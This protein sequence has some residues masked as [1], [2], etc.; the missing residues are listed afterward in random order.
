MMQNLK[1]SHQSLLDRIQKGV[2]A[3]VANDDS[4]FGGVLKK[5]E[6]RT[7]VRREIIFYAS[8]LLIFVYLAVGWANN[9]IC[10]L[11]GF[12]Y[13]SLQ[14]IRAIEA[15]TSADDCEWLMYWV[16]FAGF[17]VAEHIL[18]FITSWIPFYWLGKCLLLLWMMVPGSSG[19]SH[20]IYYLVVKPIFLKHREPIDKYVGRVEGVLKQTSDK[21]KTV[22]SKT[23]GNG[24]HLQTH[25]ID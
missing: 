3:L 14:T 22:F 25:K 11:I 16:V 17:M 9:L 21:A 19:G 5:I 12:A 10:D 24:S 4:I 7:G 15:K 20:V 18:S 13:P 2:N 6:V 8:V 1:P 23:D